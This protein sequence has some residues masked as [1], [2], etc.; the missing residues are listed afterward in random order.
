V[1]VAAKRHLLE[2]QASVIVLEKVVRA[3][4][5]STKKGMRHGLHLAPGHSQQDALRTDLKHSQNP[6][7]TASVHPP[8]DKILKR[9]AHQFR[10][11]GAFWV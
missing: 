4:I 5:L 9:D 7:C 6:L 8:L 3:A 11:L 1:A 10:I 2:A